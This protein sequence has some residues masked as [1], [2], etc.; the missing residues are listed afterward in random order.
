MEP[1]LD[2][3]LQRILDRVELVSGVGDPEAG[4]LC[5]MSLVAHLAGERHTDHPVCASSL[6]RAFAIPIND[7]MPSEVRQHL[8][9]F[10]PRILGT[11]DGRDSERAEILCRALAMEILPRLA[12]RASSGAP[13]VGL[14]RRLWRQLRRRELH[15]R[16]ERLLGRLGAG[17]SPG[18]RIALASATGQ[19]LALCARNA[20]QAEQSWNAAIGLLDRL[21]D[22]EASQRQV[23]G[24][25]AGCPSSLGVREVIPP[26]SP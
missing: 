18:D 7:C 1:G 16:V 25:T 10:A 15:R 8:K 5:V 20:G 17:G 22:V 13:G 24:P 3:P 19:L 4:K 2:L 14:S 12:G 23:P 21:C 6:I 9:P 11:N 26:H